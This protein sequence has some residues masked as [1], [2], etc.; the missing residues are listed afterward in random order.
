MKR[1][2]K[3]LDKVKEMLKQQGKTINKEELEKLI[4]DYKKKE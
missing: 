4:S 3:R 2:P 1:V